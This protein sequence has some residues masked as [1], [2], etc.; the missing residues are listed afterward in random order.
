MNE[1]TTTEQLL[2]EIGTLHMALKIVRAE[3]DAL[4]TRLQAA[5]QAAPLVQTSENGKHLTEQ[6]VG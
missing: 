4:R 1:S 3:R 6:G 5:L 2:A